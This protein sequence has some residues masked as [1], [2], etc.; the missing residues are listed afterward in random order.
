M[1]NIEF[2]KWTRWNDRTSLEG[3]KYPGVYSLAI[4]NKDLSSQE[5]NFIEEICY[6]GMT[7][8]KKG[9]QG[10][11]YQFNN[12]IQGKDGHG[13]GD[14]FKFKHSCYK[15][16]VGELYVSVRPF[17][18]DVNSYNPKDLLIMGEVSRFE[19]ECFAKYVEKFGYMPEFNDM[20]RSQK[21][22]RDP[23]ITIHKN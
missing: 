18:C 1:S 8:S 10:R 12:A 17:I 15:T 16:L 20:N 19:Y 11:L 22:R 3:L 14:R 5:F 2:S 21:A 13:G 23:K 4:S 7:N 6:F 9:L